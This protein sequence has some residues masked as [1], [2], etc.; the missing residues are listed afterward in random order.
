MELQ[1]LVRE[2]PRKLGDVLSLL[3]D[4]RMQVRVA[5]LEESHLLESLH[6][7]ANRIT[8]GLVTAALIVGAALM[9]GVEGGPR[10]LGY[11]A[12]ALGLFTVAAA[13]AGDGRALAS[14]Q[15][16]G[17]AKSAPHAGHSAGGAAVFR[18]RG[19][20]NS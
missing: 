6:K 9:M 20:L 11:P 1:A 15:S 10:L 4:N 14:D 2:A 17:R 5:G 12:I 16:R 7:I 19:F 18:R 3:A 13:I 8:A